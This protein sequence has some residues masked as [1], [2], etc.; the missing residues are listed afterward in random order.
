[1]AKRLEALARFGSL[2]Y[3]GAAFF[4][5]TLVIGTLG[6]LWYTVDIVLQLILGS[7]VLSSDGRIPKAWMRLM[8]WRN[9]NLAW[10]L[11][12]KGSF[13]WTAGIIM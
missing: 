6:L 9:E 8:E 1:M 7:E 13:S 12:G 3:T 5:A 10:G 11:F 4:V 2:T